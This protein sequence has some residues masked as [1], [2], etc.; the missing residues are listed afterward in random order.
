MVGFIGESVSTGTTNQFIVFVFP[1]VECIA[2]FLLF[3]SVT[4]EDDEPT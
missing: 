2:V 3:L 4:L 1:L